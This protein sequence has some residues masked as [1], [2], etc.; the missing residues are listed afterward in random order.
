MAIL[1]G[2]CKSC[3]VGKVIPCTFKDGITKDTVICATKDYA[4]T[5]AKDELCKLISKANQKVGELCCKTI[6]C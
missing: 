3:V 5:C 2:G 6:S 1:L 4:A